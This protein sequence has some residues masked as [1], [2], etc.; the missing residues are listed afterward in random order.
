[1]FTRRLEAVKQ[2]ITESR[3]HGFFITSLPNIRYLT[4]F[5]GS[6][7][8]L[9]LTPDRN[10]FFTDGR[11]ESQSSEEVKDARVIIAK[12]SLLEAFAHN[13]SLKAKDR[14]GI[15]AGSVSVAAFNNMKKIARHVRFAPTVAVIEEVRACKDESEIESIKQASKITDRVFNK[16]LAILKPG[17]K[18]LE[19]AAEISYWHRLFG[20]ESDAFEPIVASG[21]RGAFPHA[22]ASSNKIKRGDLV[23]IDLGCRLNGYH[24]DLTRTVSIGKPSPQMKKIH[25]IVLEAIERVLEQ[26][27]DGVQAR[28]MDS[29][30]RSS[31]RARGYGKY[32]CHSLGHGLG[33]EVHELPR[34]SGRSKDVLQ[35]GSVLTLEPGIYIPHVGGVRI[36][37]DVVIRGDGKEV[38][39][40]IPRELVIL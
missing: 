33:L 23:T 17:T 2:K 10:F 5:T 20:A 21:V 28:F 9:F 11:Y 16:I 40:S 35:N 12:G 22:R 31:I 6:N 3:L 32:F 24:C 30:A 18:E 4:G 27:R 37:D 7:A 1:M 36:E 8:I 14:I 29:V 25:A 13:V 38:L 39:S 19:V 26:A 34:V 15:E